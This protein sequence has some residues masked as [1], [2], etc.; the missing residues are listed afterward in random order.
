MEPRSI[1]DLTDEEDRREAARFI[2]M[3]ATGLAFAIPEDLD[4]GLL[5]DLF[6]KAG[7]STVV[8]DASGWP[9]EVVASTDKGLF[10]FKK[11]EEGVYRL[12]PSLRRP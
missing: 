9:R 11:V 1:Y 5:E 4:T 2:A 12:E 7:A 6:K 8:V 3:G 10:R